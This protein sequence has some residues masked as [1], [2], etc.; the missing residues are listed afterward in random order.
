MTLTLRTKKLR[1]GTARPHVTHKDI[2]RVPELS[3]D[4]E[5]R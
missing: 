2:W 5:T 3:G 1:K 4:L